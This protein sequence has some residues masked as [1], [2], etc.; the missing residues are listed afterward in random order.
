MTY[1]AHTLSDEILAPPSM[2]SQKKRCFASPRYFRILLDSSS[3]CQGLTDAVFRTV[4]KLPREPI[5]IYI[6]Y[7]SKFSTN[8]VFLSNYK[9]TCHINTD[10][11]KTSCSMLNKIEKWPYWVRYFNYFS[12]IG[13]IQTFFK[14]LIV[15]TPMW[16]ASEFWF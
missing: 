12:P 8:F 16:F 6:F 14:T 11:F 2:A 9:K 5:T 13:L 3:K 1:L 4:S 15:K 10:V 7:F